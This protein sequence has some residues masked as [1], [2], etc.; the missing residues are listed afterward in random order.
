MSRGKGA[1]S[2]RTVYKSAITGRFV[3]RSTVKSNPKTT[4]K[5]TVKK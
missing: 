3:K 4:Y 1:R 2:P 5:Q